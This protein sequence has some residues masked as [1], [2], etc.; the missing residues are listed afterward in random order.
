[1]TLSWLL[2]N[3]LLVVAIEDAVDGLLGQFL[4]QQADEPPTMAMAPQLMGLMGLPNSML[5]TVRPT[6]QT[7]QAQTL[8]VVTPR[9]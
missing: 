6:P 5:T 9:Q 7:K 8:A 1:M 2:Q 4:R 3:G